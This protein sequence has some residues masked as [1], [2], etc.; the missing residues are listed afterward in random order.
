MLLYLAAYVVGQGERDILQLF[1][2]ICAALVVVAVILY[3]IAAAS[4]YQRTKRE[5]FHVRLFSGGS[6]AAIVI[7][8]L[9]AFFGLP[10]LL[11]QCQKP[12]TSLEDFPWFFCFGVIVLS[13]G[14]SLRR[15]AERLKWRVD[16]TDE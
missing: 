5:T 16:K 2:Q 13:I 3:G 6:T 9:L 11:G 14:I 10:I 12:S 8:V 1:G 15:R 4:F 7:G